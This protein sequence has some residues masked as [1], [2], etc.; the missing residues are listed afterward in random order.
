MH[1]RMFSRSEK[2]SLLHENSFKQIFFTFINVFFKLSFEIFF[3]KN[4]FIFHKNCSLTS[5]QF[6]ILFC[7]DSFDK[8]LETAWSF[9][10]ISSLTKNVR[11]SI[12]LIHEF[13][14][15]TDLMANKLSLFI[16]APCDW[17]IHFSQTRR[18]QSRDALKDD[19]VRRRV[20]EDKKH[21]FKILRSAECLR[22]F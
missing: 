16:R 17:S 18:T 1:L 7:F 14:N 12:N 11:I 21:R 6:F 10:F 9:L 5:P 22:V 13:P 8:I 15:R 20:G 2:L 3:S 4:H 19:E